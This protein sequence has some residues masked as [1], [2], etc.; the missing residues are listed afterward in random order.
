MFLALATRFRPEDHSPTGVGYK[1]AHMGKAG[2]PFHDRIPSSLETLVYGHRTSGLNFKLYLKRHDH[3]VELP[4]EK[5]RVRL[6]I[7]MQRYGLY[8]VGLNRVS[9]LFAFGYR[10][11]FA[12]CFKVIDGVSVRN[13]ARWSRSRTLAFQGRA[14]RGWRRAGI[15]AFGHGP[16]PV[17]ALPATVAAAEW[18]TQNG[19]FK[20]IDPALHVLHPHLD[21]NALIGQA[22]RQLDRRMKQRI[23][24]GGKVGVHTKSLMPKVFS[25]SEGGGITY[26]LS[27]PDT[28]VERTLED[29]SKLV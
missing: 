1:A 28:L 16:M 6:E 19:K 4:L 3:G 8:L 2:V 23:S 13:R 22:L 12:K 25:T 29:A 5:W 15:N 27:T 9:S 14:E 20:T 7:T 10:K 24:G 18:R 21:A 11:A 26:T 17:E